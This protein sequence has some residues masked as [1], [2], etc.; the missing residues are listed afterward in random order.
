MMFNFPPEVVGGEI[1]ETK[2]WQADEC[3][4]NYNGNQ[5]RVFV[6]QTVTYSS[7]NAHGYICAT[8]EE[9]PQCTEQF[10]NSNGT[11]GSSIDFIVLMLLI[12]CSF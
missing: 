2:N 9:M 8:Q 7:G 4:I 12:A 11:R 6:D 1:S 10:E 5:G 3:N